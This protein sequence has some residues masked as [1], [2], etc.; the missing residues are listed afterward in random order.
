MPPPMTSIRFGIAGSASAP[1]EVTTRGS[2]GRNGSITAS[3]P[4]AMIAFSKPTETVPPLASATSIAC[5][6]LKR[7][8]PSITETLRSFA[9]CASPPVSLPTTASLCAR[10]FGRSMRGAENPIPC[11]RNASASAISA[12]T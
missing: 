2:S 4:A 3:D 5:G 7:P 6:S 10:S 1:V 12:A 8:V 9:I 11:A